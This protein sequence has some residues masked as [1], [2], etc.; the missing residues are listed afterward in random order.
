M[1][2]SKIV[3]FLIIP[4]DG[5]WDTIFYMCGS[6][7]DVVKTRDCETHAKDKH[8]ADGCTL[9]THAETAMTDTLEEPLNGVG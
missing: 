9:Y 3:K 1:P 8:N 4:T 6:C 5:P 7:G 2:N